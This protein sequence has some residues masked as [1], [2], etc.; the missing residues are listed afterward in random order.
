MDP[1]GSSHTNQ[2]HLP[3]SA[4]L[5]QDV[6][7]ALAAESSPLQP[8][9]QLHGFSDMFEGSSGQKG[10]QKYFGFRSSSSLSFL[11]AI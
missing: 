8:W 1:Q 6:G 11:N 7:W 2:H 4:P 9:S 5:V 3:D 10:F